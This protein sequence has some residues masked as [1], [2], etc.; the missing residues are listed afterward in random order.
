MTGFKDVLNNIDKVEV[1]PISIITGIENIS[2]PCTDATMEEAMKIW[3][4]LEVS[5]DPRIGHGLAAIQIGIFKKV[6]I[7]I[8]DNKILR[9][10]NTRI[11]SM[12]SPIVIWGEGCLS[13]PKKVVN[14]ERFTTITIEDDI[15]GKAVI[16]SDAGLLPIIIQHEVDH[17]EG[18]TILDH[19]LKPIRKEKIGR[20]DPCPCGS[21]QKYKKCCLK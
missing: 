17:F 4:I 11:V 7:V 13:L 1:T 20:N 2:T 3:P 12:T 6:A 15:M 19:Q 5:L 14:T 18:K 16:N 9:L 8:H 21:G 10:L